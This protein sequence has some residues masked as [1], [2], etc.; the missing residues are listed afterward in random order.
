MTLSGHNE[1]ISSALWLSEKEVC[2][3]SWD[4]TI[5]IWDM[6]KADNTATLVN[7]TFINKETLHRGKK[8]FVCRLEYE[9]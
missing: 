5:R 8:F 4:H 7:F 1:G 3:G 2:T 9:Q 6:E